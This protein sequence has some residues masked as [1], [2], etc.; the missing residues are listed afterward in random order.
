M[1]RSLISLALLA[2][3]CNG[4]APEATGAGASTGAGAG[5]STGAG[6]GAGASTG[7][8]AAASAK[9]VR[10]VVLVVVD[11]L[12]TWSFERDRA[13]LTGGIARLLEG[14]VYYAGAELPYA[15]TYT[16]TGHAT[17]ATGAPP[18]IHGIVANRWFDRAT[19]KPREATADP[20]AASF[21]ATNGALVGNGQS[22]RWLLAPGIADAL[23]AAT[24]GRGKSV[25]ISLKERAAIL[26]L[27]RSPDAA[28]WYDERQP[29]MTTSRAYARSEPTWLLDL[30]RTHPVSERFGDVWKPRDAALL[31]KLTGVPDDA[32]GEGEGEGGLGHTFPHVLA[33]GGKPALALVNT[34][35]GTDLL[36]DTAESAIAAMRL[37]DDEVA[38]VLLI[39]VSSHDYAGHAWGQESWERLDLLLDLDRRLGGFLERLDRVVGKDDYAVV[40]TSDHG[41]VP[42]FER[43]GAPVRRIGPA[44]IL[45]AAERAIVPLLGRGRWT[46]SYQ[47]NSVSMSPA[48]R[49]KP[50]DQQAAALAAA[51]EAI[52]QLPGMG[53]VAPTASLTG[54]C[55][56][57]PAAERF[58][59]E[60]IE[61]SRN[62]EL[63]A[64][65]ADGGIASDYPTGTSHGAPSAFERK[66][67]IL[68]MAPGLSPRR[69]DRPVSMLAVAA[70][71]T[72]LLGVPPPR[73]TSTPPLD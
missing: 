14:G 53:L 54:G 6:A 34:P 64:S 12:A 66:V 4:P 28:I 24:D 5:A 58:A 17:I 50:T 55:D 37:G 13:A 71:V 68:V 9:P 39:S 29:A 18:R 45:D 51:A 43:G 52:R 42:M 3:A 72:R 63:W 47:A 60:A 59:C 23:R 67:P 56:A 16:A 20:D 62:G 10:L 61:P 19:N 70:T 27:G 11:Q 35:T 73:E 65:V 49:A 8:G 1:Q 38:D 69:D 48:F 7:A 22:S 31:A 46:A 32:P 33:A 36:F 41:A 44:V 30:E 21:S 25:A 40:L 26:G 15:S 57:R 2:L